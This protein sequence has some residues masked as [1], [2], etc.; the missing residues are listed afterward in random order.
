MTAHGG[1]FAGTFA[2]ERVFCSLEAEMAT[3]MPDSLSETDMA[4]LR[5]VQE[6]A[7]LTIETIAQRVGLS[8]SAAQRRLQRLREEKVILREVAILDPKKIGAGVTMLVEIE[9]ERD[10]PELLPALH[11]WL[12]RTPQVQ[13]AW[14]VTGRGDYTLVIVSPSIEEFDALI[15]RLVAENRNIRKFTTSV[16]LKTLKRSLAVPVG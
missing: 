2:I 9:L 15:E 5:L 16:V 12:A 4:I 1:K 11:Q 13:Q 14:Y 10:R 7:R 3:D 6:D 8:P